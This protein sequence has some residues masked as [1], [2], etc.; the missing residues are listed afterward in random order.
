MPLEWEG[1]RTVPPLTQLLLPALPRE[2]DPS[3][4]PPSLASAEGGLKNPR[5]C[6]L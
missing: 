2:A 5:A 1:D 3:K 4:N 6:V